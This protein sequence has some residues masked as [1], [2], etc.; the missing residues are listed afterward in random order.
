MYNFKFYVVSRRHQNEE[1]QLAERGNFLPIVTSSIY[2]H[3]AAW[4]AS[5]SAMGASSLE[6]CG[7]PPAAA[8]DCGPDRKLLLLTNSNNQQHRF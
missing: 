8:A 2:R 4:P 1:S 6:Q 7:V 5:C 3:A